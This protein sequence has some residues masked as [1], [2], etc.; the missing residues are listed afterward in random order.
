MKIWFRRQCK[1]SIE[2]GLIVSQDQRGG[3][4]FFY[5]P[6]IIY[7]ELD[8]TKTIFF[9]NRTYQAREDELEIMELEEIIPKAKE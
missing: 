4:T 2:L 6:S 1:S 5:G 8:S 9:A 3:T 7:D